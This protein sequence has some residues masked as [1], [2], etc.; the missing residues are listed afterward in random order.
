MEV[1]GLAR[2]HPVINETTSPNFPRFLNNIPHSI[3]FVLSKCDVTTGRVISFSVLVRG[4]R[5]FSRAKCIAV[6]IHIAIYSI[7]RQNIQ[8]PLAK[9]WQEGNDLALPVVTSH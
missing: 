5:S 4:D 3:S 6:H 8:S 7:G 2:S 9:I 1:R